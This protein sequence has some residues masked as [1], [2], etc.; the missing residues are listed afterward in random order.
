MWKKFENIFNF[1][2]IVLVRKGRA[3][4]TTLYQEVFFCNPGGRGVLKKVNKLKLIYGFS[5]GFRMTEFTTFCVVFGGSFSKNHEG[6]AVH[7]L[8]EIKKQTSDL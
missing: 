8:S 1:K 4:Y 7:F 3:F 5:G 2:K 6:S